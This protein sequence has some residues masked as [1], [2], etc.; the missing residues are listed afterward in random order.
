MFKVNNKGTSVSIVSTVSV[1][2]FNM[3]L[4]ADTVQINLAETS[5]KESGFNEK[6]YSDDCIL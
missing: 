6:L 1:V 3:Q 2:N 5:R 4:P